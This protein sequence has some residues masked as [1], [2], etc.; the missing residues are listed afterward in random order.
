MVYDVLR[1]EILAGR[2]PPGTR[3]VADK[4]A[5]Q[6]AVSKL[7]V[8]G[9]VDRLIGEGWLQTRAHIGA[10]VPE[11]SPEEILET[12]IIRAVVEGAAVRI[13]AGHVSAKI[14]GELRELVN[15]MDTAAARDDWE[16]PELN[17]QFHGLAFSACPYPSL[18]SMATGLLGKTCRLRTVR[19]LPSYLPRSQQ[20]HR[21]L[22]DA[23]AG[24]DGERAE[25]IVR[26]HVEHA[27]RLLWQY[28]MERER[29][30]T[31]RS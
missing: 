8:R 17:Y 28:A 20:E 25:L 12:S 18:R 23:I 31:A 1:R 27:G 29:S 7:P 11:L 2:Y 9:A 4:I 14:L 13:C 5:S 21:A 10:V 22:V 30:E 16:Y 24:R 6:L 3:I 15:R 19:F 26:Q